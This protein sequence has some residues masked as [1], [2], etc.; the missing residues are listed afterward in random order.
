MGSRARVNPIPAGTRPA[1]GDQGERAERDKAAGGD[2][3]DET[4]RGMADPA[5]PGTACGSIGVTLAA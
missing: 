5:V 4:D 2:A 1:G 3:N